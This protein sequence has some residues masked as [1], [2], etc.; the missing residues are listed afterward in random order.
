MLHF[1]FFETCHHANRVPELMMWLFLN[2]SLNRSVFFS[3]LTCSIDVLLDVL[4]AMQFF[5]LSLTAGTQKGCGD[6]E[7]PFQTRRGSAESLNS[8][9]ADLIPT[10]ILQEVMQLVP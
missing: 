6:R 5:L 1:H 10:R 7:Q 3:L 9:E 4:V 8:P 2:P